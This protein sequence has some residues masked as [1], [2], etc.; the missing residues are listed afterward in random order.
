MKI[1]NNFM[2]S[3][4]KNN[5][6]KNYSLYKNE[7]QHVYISYFIIFIILLLLLFLDFFII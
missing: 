6:K 1:T 2:Y 7:L 4:F 3:T 5:K